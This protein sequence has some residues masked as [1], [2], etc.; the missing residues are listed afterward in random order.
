MIQQLYLAPFLKTQ[1]IIRCGL[2]RPIALEIR[3]HP[4][5]TENDLSRTVDFFN[6]AL[7][8]AAPNG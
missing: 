3:L 7:H 1:A 2:R 4:N 8:T 5:R 6:A